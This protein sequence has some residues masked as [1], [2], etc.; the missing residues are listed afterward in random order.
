MDN[1]NIIKWIIVFG[2]LAF[3][4]WFGI[5]D[6]IVRSEDRSEDKIEG[7]DGKISNITL[8]QCGTECTISENCHGFGYKP[9][10][11]TCYL[12]KR[13]ILGEPVESPYQSEYSKLDRRC[14]KI[15]PIDDVD[16]INDLTLTQ[17]SVY[18]CSDGSNNENT[19]FQYA[20]L[21]ASS[22]ETGTMIGHSAGRGVPTKVANTEA[23]STPVAVNYDLYEIDYPDPE[24]GALK[25]VEPNFP[26]LVR[27]NDQE[28]R[29][30][31]EETKFGAVDLNA[32]EQVLINDELTD[33]FGRSA[34]IESDM[35]YLGQYLLGHQCV[36]NVPLYDCLKFCANDG[37]C[38]GTE[39]NKSIVR[40]DGKTSM[41]YE[42]VCCPKQV[43]KKIIP[44]R[45]QYNRGKFYVKTGLD[46][47]KARDSIM[48]SRQDFRR[49]YSVSDLKTT[50]QDNPRFDLQMTDRRTADVYH[51][52]EQDLSNVQP[53]T[54]FVLPSDQEKVNYAT[55]LGSR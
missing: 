27:L 12:S 3:L 38:A 19:E 30:I 25:D 31:Q 42:N 24:L 39:W 9:V 15:N 52:T 13:P 35:E 18:V 43:I 14:N 20:N 7:Y 29:N 50:I 4:I 16:Y 1:T 23:V 36:V 44:R 22:L 55:D 11:S 33:E 21:G 34:F 40:S 26:K 32:R 37:K 8:T 28:I 17:N 41:V 45:N 10:I 6:E 48:L 49:P 51:H 2:L 54:N 53:I 46:K 5:S 47:I